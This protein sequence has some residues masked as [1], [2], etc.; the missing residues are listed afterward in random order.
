MGY[1]YLNNNALG[2]LEE[3]CT[4]RAISCA[5]GESWDTVYERLSDSARDKGT[6]M[7]NRDF[8]IDYL[9]SRYKRVYTDCMTVGCASWEYRDNIVLITMVGHITCSKYGVIYDTFD[10][11]DRSV[12]FVWIVK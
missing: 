3:D 7:D 4:V 10:P 2:K 12:E 5:I 11:R 8:I 1:R 6:M 9:D